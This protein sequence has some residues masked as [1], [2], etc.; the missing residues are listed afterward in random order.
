MGHLPF[1]LFYLAGGFTSG[2]FQTIHVP[3]STLPVVG[4]SGAIAAVMGAYFLMYPLAR[5]KVLFLL[6]IFPIVF[7]IPALVFLPFWFLSQ[8][9]HVF[10]PLADSSNVAWWAHVGG[11]VVGVVLVRLFLRPR[12]E[13]RRL[14]SDEYAWHA[15]WHGYRY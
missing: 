12:G 8:V 13:R 6:V 4:A 5:I 2:V 9:F 3:Y 1:L 11:F 7:Y 14:H 15:A 10:S